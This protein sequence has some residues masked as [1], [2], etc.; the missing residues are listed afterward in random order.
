MW[1]LASKGAMTLP[2]YALSPM[3]VR[4][5]TEPGVC[6]SARKPGEGEGEGEGEGWGSG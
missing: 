2:L 6:D 4:P 3:L 5:G 1:K